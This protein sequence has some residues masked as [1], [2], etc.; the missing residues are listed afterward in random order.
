MGKICNIREKNF[1]YSM[2]EQDNG[3]SGN[4]FNF[5][6]CGDNEPYEMLY[7]DE[8]QT[9]LYINNNKYDDSAKREQTEH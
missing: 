5:R 7:G 3:R 6:F 9:F 8:S 2:K 1:S 4:I